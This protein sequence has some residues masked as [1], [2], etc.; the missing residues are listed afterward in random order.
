LSLSRPAPAPIASVLKRESV[1]LLSTVASALAIALVLRVVLFQPYTIPSSSMEPGL[2]TGDYLVVAKFPYGWSRASLPLNPP[3]PHGRFLGHGPVRGDVVVFLLPRDESQTYVK[4]VM[5]LPGD[6]VQVIG[7]VVNVNGHT[8]P[9]TPSGDTFDHDQPD[10]PVREMTEPKPNGHPY[11]T[12]GGEPDH[13]GDN[14][15]VYTVPPGEYFMMGDNRDNSLDSRWPREVGV[16]FVPA[17]N[18]VGK[19]EIVLAS[20]RSGVSLFKPWTWV[21]RLDVHRL[22]R[23]IV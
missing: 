9:R 4:R 22:L 7:G 6:R 21:T 18:I 12:F 14:T 19:A 11:V 1:E 2:V 8:I 17:E 3:L 13:E 20:W 23:P 15:G 5:G 10:R 16:G